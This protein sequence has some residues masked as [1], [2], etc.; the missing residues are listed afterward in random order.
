M[1]RTASI[2]A[3]SA[4]KPPLVRAGVC[5]CIQGF[6]A[7]RAHDLTAV[8]RSTESRASLFGFPMAPS[9]PDARLQ[10]TSGLLPGTWHT[11]RPCMIAQYNL[12]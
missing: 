9:V 4:S 11:P 7:N 12:A 1:G 10:I 5:A 8:Q 6:R 2:Q 3:Q